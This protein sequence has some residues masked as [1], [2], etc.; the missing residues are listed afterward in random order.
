MN[1]SSLPDPNRIWLLDTSGLNAHDLIADVGGLSAGLAFDS[2]GN[3][4]YGTSDLD[5][6]TFQTT[7]QL[8]AY[9]AN[10][11]AS[12]IRWFEPVPAR[13]PS[14]WPIFQG[15]VRYRRR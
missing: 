3:L 13:M 10:Q 4:I 1:S 12:A 6:S 8:I 7:G 15:G 2:E 14:S 11:V 5:F 9:T